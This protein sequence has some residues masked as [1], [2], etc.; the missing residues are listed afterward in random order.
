MGCMAAA[1]RGSGRW[2]TINQA[3]E[4]GVLVLGT[5][6][7]EETD[8]EAHKLMFQLTDLNS[9][10]LASLLVLAVDA[11]QKTGRHAQHL[12]KQGK[13]W[14]PVDFRATVLRGRV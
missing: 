14:A 11:G 3:M 13:T 9:S 12:P 5:A 6:P 8:S 7:W 2:I 4:V 1:A 10:K